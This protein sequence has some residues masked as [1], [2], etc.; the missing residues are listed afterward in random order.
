MWITSE[1]IKEL[2]DAAAGKIECDVVIKNGKIVNVITGEIYE[3]EVGIKGGHIAHV[4]CNIDEKDSPIA[5]KKYIDAEGQYIVPGFIDAHIHIES[6]LLTPRNFAKAVIPSG[7]TTVV[8]DPHEIANVYGIRGVKYMHDSSEGLP[9]RQYILAPSCVPAVLGL[10]NA[11]A[12]FHRKEIEE[13]LK[14]DRVLGLGEV[15]DYIGVIES[16]ERMVEILDAAIKNNMFIQGHAPSLTGKDLSA[17]LCAGA[18]S[19]HESRGSLEARDKMRRGM[20]VDARESSIS[21]NVVDIVNGVK[22]FRYLTHLTLCTDDREVHDVLEAGH[23]NDVVRVAVKAGMH[24]VDAIRSATLNIAK[25]IGIKNLGAIAPGYLADVNIIEDLVEFNVKKV[26]YE[27]ELVA[28]DG[29][30][31][32]EIKAESFD[33]E[34]EN[35][36]HVEKL[37]LEDFKI[38]APIENGKIKAKVMTYES[39]KSSMT[40]FVEEELVVKNGY[41]DISDDPD[42]NFVVVI[43]RHGKINSKAIALVRGFG[44]YKGAVGSTVSHDSHNLTVVFSEAEEG[45]IVAKDLVN[46]GGGLSCAENNK[47]KEHLTLEVAGL[48][49]T[50]EAKELS[51][52]ANNMKKAL[53]E[54]GLTEIQNPLLR[55]VTLALPVIPKVKMSDIGIIDV[56]ERRITSIWE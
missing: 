53:K 22:D 3:G 56:L 47:I 12:E 38:K 45:L 29:I 42:L 20:Y 39:L 33:I 10:E 18:V 28:E 5:G 51:I 13:M 1:N 44:I 27:G 16:D 55:I 6:T 46:M 7:T 2:I 32:K 34:K 30:L 8:T 31:L 52:E 9:M 41:I 43:N 24:P 4:S 40:S 26:I 15:M 19:C 36:V 50:K 37:V 14:M 21:K 25:E 23:M 35:S 17:Y 54:L 11:G 48:M 49:S